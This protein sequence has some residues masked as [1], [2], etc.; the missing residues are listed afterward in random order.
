MSNRQVVFLHVP[1]TGGTSLRNSISR[2]FDPTELFFIY[3][4]RKEFHSIH[5]LK[6]LT[7]EQKAKYLVYMGH[8]SFNPEILAETNPH[9]V[10]MVRHPV[11]RVISYYHHVMTN[12]PKWSDDKVSLM[13]YIELSEDRQLS[14]HQTRLLSGVVRG[15]TPQRHL[16]GA[17]ENIQHKFSFVGL[18]ERFD[19]SAVG[20]CKAVGWHPLSIRRDNQGI[21]KPSAHFFSSQELKTIE[22]L[23]E[24][25]MELYRVAVSQFEQRC[26]SLGVISD[27]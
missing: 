20:M 23:N 15:G 1:K 12:N 22:D 16:D 5:K 2:L 25:D 9:Y 8:M 14:N 7:S 24:Y 18:T 19:D 27:D 3:N 21:G 6:G 11:E 4:R 10:T 17:I 26:R 13:K